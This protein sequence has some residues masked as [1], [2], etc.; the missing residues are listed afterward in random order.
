MN[1]L[2][3]LDETYSEYSLA[4][5]DDLNRFWSKGQGHSTPSRWQ[6]NPRWRWGVEVLSQKFN[7][8]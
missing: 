2:G 5:T 6:R 7:L 8:L 4:P 3:N 1:G